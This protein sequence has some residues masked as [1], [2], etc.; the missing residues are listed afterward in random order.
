MS[1]KFV[2]IMIVIWSVIIVALIGLLVFLFTSN[3][4]P[5]GWIKVGNLNNYNQNYEKTYAL[6]DID[7]ISVG[8]A[9]GDIIVNQGGSD[10]IKVAVRNNSNCEITCEQSGSSIEVKQEAHGFSLFSLS[11][12]TVSKVTVTVP[13]AYA[14]Q[15]ELKTASGD[16]KLTGNYNLEKFTHNSASGKFSADK[17][18]ADSIEIIA[19]SGDIKAGKLEGECEVKTTSGSIKI[20]TV[21]GNGKF[22]TVSGSIKADF[23][24]ITGN[25]DAGAISGGIHFGIKDD[26]NCSVD[27]KSASG[28]IN[29]DY[30]T[31][32]GGKSKNAQI[33]SG[34][35]AVTINTISGNIS[36]NK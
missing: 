8:L 25:V 7:K 16:A 27:M 1:K 22:N 17:I 30:P 32:G 19:V 29:S 9:S 13:E 15:L 6:S 4:K 34:T 35:N 24:A 11:F 23:E 18:K 20:D 21:N 3:F 36:I 26:A 31:T 5:T 2:T 10:E 14:K 12:N 33:G 28:S